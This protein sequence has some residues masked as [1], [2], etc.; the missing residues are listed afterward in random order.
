MHCCAWLIPSEDTQLQSQLLKAPAAP[1]SHTAAFV[2]QPFSPLSSQDRKLQIRFI[3][4][5]LKKK[6]KAVVF[7]IFDE[8]HL[9]LICLLFVCDWTEH[10]IQLP[11]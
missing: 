6:K 3:E 9:N 10:D 2:L 4:I 1:C 5:F 8:N 7:I 11:R